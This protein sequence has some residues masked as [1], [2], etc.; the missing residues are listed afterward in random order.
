[1]RRELLLSIFRGYYSEELVD[2]LLVWE[3]ENFCRIRFKR[4]RR[5]KGGD[6]R[7]SISEKVNYIS[8]NIS[9]NPFRVLVTL[10]H[11]IAHAKQNLIS[12]DT[13]PHGEE[14]KGIYRQMMYSVLR[15]EIFPYDLEV[16]IERHFRS[17]K[18]TDY[19]D[20][21]LI[22]VIEQYNGLID[23]R[24]LYL[25]NEADE[26]E[27][28]GVDVKVSMSDDGFVFLESSNIHSVK[29]DQ[30]LSVLY[31]RFL[32]GSCYF[33]YDVPRHVYAELL[34]ADSVGR[35]LNKNIAYSYRYK[36]DANCS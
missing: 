20:S 1:M 27:A 36:C 23:E 7:F 34:L 13:R 16:A 31:V 19:V 25:L 6:C 29:Y 21:S 4:D 22:K 3:K 15:Y 8:I 9:S 24:S 35:Y 26:A 32:N 12:I 5:T 30:D 18:Y 28:E 33:Y 14:W 11:E 17:P 10:L 2:L